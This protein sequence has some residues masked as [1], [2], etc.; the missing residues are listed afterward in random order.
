MLASGKWRSFAT[1]VA[2]L[3]SLSINPPFSQADLAPFLAKLHF[4]IFEANQIVL[5]GILT[6]MQ[7]I[8]QL[9][10]RHLA[11]CPQLAHQSFQVVFLRLLAPKHACPPRTRLGEHRLASLL[12]V[13]QQP[14]QQISVEI[15]NA[16]NRSL[17]TNFDSAWQP[18]GA[19]P[20]MQPGFSPDAIYD[21]GKLQP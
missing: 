10:R 9:A 6:D 17:A 11:V 13:V 19:G 12:Q 20:K 2:S 7:C 14:C 8:G 16:K 15:W 21:S 4:M 3:D 5:D 1:D 18:A